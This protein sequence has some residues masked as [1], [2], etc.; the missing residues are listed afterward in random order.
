MPLANA[1]VPANDE[2]IPQV[3]GDSRSVR[4]PPVGALQARTRPAK[5]TL[6]GDIQA[7]KTKG[8]AV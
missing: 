5:L 8:R 6:D 2:V 7:P 1:C 3:M 4:G